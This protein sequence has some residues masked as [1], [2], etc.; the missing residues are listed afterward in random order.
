M[1]AAAPLDSATQPSGWQHTAA[2]EALARLLAPRIPARVFDAH[3]HFYRNADFNPAP[4][5]MRAGPAVGDRGAWRSALG[6]Q[7]GGE[8]RLVGGL[9]LP[10]PTLHTP[11]PDVNRFA[12]EQTQGDPTLRTTLL[13]S[14]QDSAESVAP[15]LDLPGVIGFKP[16]H[17]YSAVKPTPDS[18]VNDFVPEWVW[19][20]AHQ[21]R[22][23]IML[24]LVR[25]AALLDPENIRQIRQ[26]CLAYPEARLLLAHAGRSFHA[27]NAAGVTGLTGLDN[28]WLDS[29]AICEAE[30]LTQILNTLGPRRLMF[31]SDFPIS[32]QRGRCVT[33]GNGFAWITTD[34][35]AWN[36]SAFLGEPVAVGLEQL[37]ALLTATDAAGLNREDLDDVFC[38]N[39]Q[40]ALGLPVANEP[41]TQA[42]YRR[43]KQLIPGGVQLLSKRPENHAPERWP[44]YFREAR[45]CE[46]WDLEGRRYVDVAAHGIGACLLGFRDPDVTAAVQR[47]VNLGSFSTLNPPEEVALAELLCELHP[48]ANQARFTRGGGEA[49]ATAVRIARATTDRP[50]VAICGYHGWHDWYLAANLG[51]DD[52]L[53]GHLLPGLEPLGVPGSLRG[54]ACAFSY[55]DRAAFDAIIERHGKQ[56][57]A[58]IMEP[59]RFQNPPAG[60]LEHIRDRAHAAGA[61]LVFDEI[62]IGFRLTLGGAH[63]RLGVNPDIAV[64]A[65]SLANGHP[66]G[67]VIGTREAMQG[68]HR[69]FISS[70]AW[71]ESVGPAAALATLRKMQTVDVPARCRAAGEQVLAAWRKAAARHNL[72]IV[73]DDGFPALAR[74]SFKHPEAQTLKTAY[75]QRLLTRRFLA[76]TVFYATLAHTPDVL[77]SYARAIDEVF[78]ELAEGI[79]SGNVA[80]LLNGPVAHV[81]FTRLL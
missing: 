37:R 61:L 49:M 55:G 32:Q 28:V 79:A 13:V 69:S 59:C 27:P 22:W 60:F 4:A 62:T 58:V 71:T 6:R 14:P 12:V 68:A 74:F 64:F 3:L 76:G 70:T 24:H 51:D 81:G 15:F 23:C 52:E 53:R 29:S 17:I 5:F 48:W 75:I 38:R 11:R 47:R 44:A 16:Y 35:V 9:V 40:R 33:L 10:F 25:D 34:Q 2:D 18:Y 30:P 78:G 21:R 42:L 19:R 63:L 46:I 31:G 43:A 1:Q 66:M 56:L 80:A 73:T 39:A 41:D 54:T 20:I 26:R 57:A 36:R 7:L 8:E 65:K 77:E 67:A 72:A 45:G 50:V